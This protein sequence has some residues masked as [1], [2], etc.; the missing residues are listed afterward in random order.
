[1]TFSIG[2]A[3]QRPAPLSAAGL[4]LALLLWPRPAEAHGLVQRA[5][6]PIPEWLFGWAATVVLVISFVAL[7][8]LW[9]RPK[10]ERERWRP[11]P[12]GAGRV[13]AG[14]AV[15]AT[16]QLLGAVMLVVVIWSGLA[17][18]QEVQ[19]NLAPT[20]IFITWWV[21]LAFASALL[22]DVFKA[23]NPWRAWGRAAQRAAIRLRGGRP[24]PARPYP[25]WL[26]RWPAAIGVLGFA[27]LELASGLG[28]QPHVLATAAIVYSALTFACMAVYGVDEWIERGEAFSVYFN[29]LSRL[30]PFERRDGE[31]G[32]RP[33]LGGLPQLQPLPGTVALVCV[34][35][36]T[37]TFDGLSQGRWWSGWAAGL[38]DWLASL[39][40]SA[41][42]G[43]TL[44]ATAGVALCVG[45]VAL[46]Y[47]LG[48]LGARSV[49]GAMGAGRLRLAF[50]H[51]LVPIA[52]VYVVAHYLT[53][54]LVEGQAITYLASDPLGRGWDLFGTAQRAIDYGVISQNQTWYAQVAAVVAGHVAA[55]M[56]AHDRA[57]VVYRQSRLAVRSQYWML[58]VMV[59]FTTLALW[60]LAQAGTA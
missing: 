48:I 27:W 56:L 17:G 13:L 55:L 34:M 18:R 38:G 41:T 30:S 45:A 32:V 23:F 39:G 35:I 49:G 3:I 51:S 36:G 12:G 52:M 53:F 24:L 42:T 28:E 11:L 10:L 15:E 9:S 6:L 14:S 8:V 29:L 46:V 7:A 60:L 57:L 33:L 26:G 47:W 50:V 59:G 21:G 31:I 25:Q 37:V 43:T 5:S 4:V 20:F 58:G 40:V 1:M 22:G 44:A 19:S 16:C 54:F 2:R